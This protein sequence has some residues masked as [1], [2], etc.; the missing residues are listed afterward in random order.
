MT[1]FFPWLLL[2]A[3]VWFASMG[4]YKQANNKNLTTDDKVQASTNFTFIVGGVILLAI[5]GAIFN[6]KTVING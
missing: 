2:I 1:K 6:L 5:S 3:G 4:S